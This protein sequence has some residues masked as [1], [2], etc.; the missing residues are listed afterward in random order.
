[1]SRLDKLEKRNSKKRKY[2]YILRVIFIFV[3]IINTMLCAFVVDR[4]ANS[5]LGKNQYKIEEVFKS[6]EPSMKKGL[7][8]VG[9]ATSKILNKDNIEKIEDNIKKIKE[10]FTK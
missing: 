2:K 3:M 6:V 5:M 10:S 7:D 9:K 4:R 8:E 1:M